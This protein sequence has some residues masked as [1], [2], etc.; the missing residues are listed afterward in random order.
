MPDGRVA[1]LSSRILAAR[2]HAVFRRSRF[3]ADEERRALA[4]RPV[5]SENSKSMKLHV[6]VVWPTSASKSRI[7]AATFV[8][9]LISDGVY[10][11]GPEYS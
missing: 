9:V 7:V 3:Q 4:I 1:D 6:A 10:A 2:E 8:N 5:P 11:S